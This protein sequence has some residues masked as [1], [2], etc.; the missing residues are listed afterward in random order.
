MEAMAWGGRCLL[1]EVGEG[2]GGGYDQYT[3]YTCVKF[4]R[5]KQ[6]KYNLINDFLRSWG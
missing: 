2:V 1:G 4:S 6:I 5:N 3:R